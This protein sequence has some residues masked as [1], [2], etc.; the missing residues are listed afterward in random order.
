MASSDQPS[1]ADDSVLPPRGSTMLRDTAR[2]LPVDEHGRV[3][4]LHGAEPD[5][6][7]APM[8]F[9][10]GGAIEPGETHQQAAARELHEETGLVAAPE[11]FG[12]PV[13]A[14]SL[15]FDWAG[16]HIVQQQTFFV[17]ALAHADVSFDGHD[18]FERDTIDAARWWDPDELAADGTVANDELMGL[19]RR[20]SGLA[21]QA[22]LSRSAVRRWMGGA[23]GSRG[24]SE[25]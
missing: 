9:S 20:A 5:H 17:I 14:G 12:E 19:V 24:G 3:L 18:R 13:F 1:P 21:R 15:E 23:P 4:L 22:A 10:V 25:V 7:E 8:W 2:V 16:R 6:P 11:A